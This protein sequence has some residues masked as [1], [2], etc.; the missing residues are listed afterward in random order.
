[1]KVGALIFAHNNRDIDYALMALI[2]GGLAKKHLKIPVSLVSDDTTIAWMK[3]SGIYTRA[4]E[5]F[6]HIIEVEKPVSDNTRRLHDGIENT[7]VV[8]FVNANRSNACMLTPYDR[9]VLLDCDYFIFSD[10]LTEYF[11]VDEDILISKAINDVVG[12]S[13]VG[14]HDKYV[15]DTGVHLYWATTVI[16]TKNEKSK[17]FFEMVSYVRDNY[18]YYADLFRFDPRQYRNDIS[19]SVA[20]HI[21]NG[22]ETDLGMSLPPVLTTID[23]DILHSVD[24]NGK[25]TFLISSQLSS[26]YCAAA[27]K[28]QDIH[29]MNKQSVVRHADALLELI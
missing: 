14:Y 27:F 8:P 17:A 21:L 24:A 3:Q 12:D 28:N 26:S 29:I 5:V 20:K 15:S 25:L 13:R 4:T 23:K 10:R 6:E 16:F 9:T 7:K 22:F 1:M 18:E 2:S 19:F 11:D